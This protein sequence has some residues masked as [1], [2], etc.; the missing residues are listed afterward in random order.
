MTTAAPSRVAPIVAAHAI[1]LPPVPAA[2]AER[3]GLVGEHVTMHEVY[4]RMARAAPTLAPVLLMGETGTGR[5]MI[6]HCI[7]EGSPVSDG[8]WVAV[9]C[10]SEDPAQLE[11][12]LF[13]IERESE[14][15]RM[16][17]VLGGFEKAAG[18][19]IFLD[20][21]A[22]LTPALQ[23]RLLRVVQH[24]EIERVG[25]GEIIP[26]HARIIAS[27]SRD[28]RKATSD[29]RFRDDLYFKLAIV[30]IHVPRLADRGDDLLLLI[31]SFVQHALRRAHAT[32]RVTQLDPA[33]Y[34]VLLTHRWTANV[35]ELRQAIEHAVLV[36]PGETIS[37]AD[38]PDA[39]LVEER[40]SHP[41]QRV[42]PPRTPERES[43]AA[44]A[45]AA[46]IPTLAEVEAR[47]IAF[48]LAETQG[49]IHV[50]ADVLGVH[51]NTLTRKI[52]EYGL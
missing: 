49:V 14:Q 24:N 26:V 42:S 45:R 43:G 5:E 8:P 35:R 29:G 30:T 34:R 38:L 44:R 23:A 20:D 16:S 3:C 46:R 50:A 6:A 33:A 19:T 17:R 48:V 2:R 11:G 52:R 51:R 9:R 41:P 40:A 39:L 18:G 13:G 22:D 27:S 31:A 1:P 12:E 28:L 4:R 21:I 10:A 32:R 15:G 37:L 7:H 25:S 47:H 36:T